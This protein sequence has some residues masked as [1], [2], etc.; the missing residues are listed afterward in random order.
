MISSHIH[1]NPGVGCG[2]RLL[3]VLSCT[4]GTT[5][6]ST[7]PQNARQ[8]AGYVFVASTLPPRPCFDCDLK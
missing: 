7:K 3:A 2:T 5:S 1:R 6:H 8:V 4:D